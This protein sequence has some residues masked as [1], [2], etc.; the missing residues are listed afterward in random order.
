M[1]SEDADRLRFA[2]EA[3]DALARVE[4]RLQLHLSLLF[5][6]QAFL[7][8][9]ERD[10]S[11]V[12]FADF[13]DHL[14][15]AGRYDGI[16]GVGFAMTVPADAEGPA[17]DAIARNYGQGFPIRP[18][19]TDQAIRT[20]IV[21]IEPQD[22]RNRAAVG[23]DMFSAETRRTAMIAAART[24]G[25]QAT[26]P[27]RLVQEIDENRQQGFLIYLP[28]FANPL[29]TV[30]EAAATRGF[31]YAPFR[32]GDLFQAAFGHK[33]HLPVHVEV[34]DGAV[35]TPEARIYASPEAA[36]PQWGE[37]LGATRELTVAGRKWLLRMHPTPEF[38][39]IGSGYPAALLAAAVVMLALVLALLTLVQS[40]R[41]EAVAAL[42]AEGVR[43]LAQKDLMLGEMNHRIKNSIAR[44]IAIARQTARGASGLDDFMERYASRLNAMAA[45]QEVLTRSR[46]GRA[47]M[48]ELLTRELSQVLGEGLENCNIAGPE[49]ELGEAATQALGLTFHE[50]AT[51]ALKYGAL[52]SQNGSLSVTWR[53]VGET[54]AIDWTETGGAAPV[55]EPQRRGFGT[56]LINMSIGSELGGTIERHFA[57]SG[58][59][60]AIRFPAEAAGAAPA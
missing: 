15:L 49:V 3:D 32:V 45:A 48:D 24:G 56:R 12:Q 34:F 11:R 40:R 20:P 54:V 35:A 17:V 26:G 7:A 2:Q 4:A 59:R 28:L 47:K 31:V 23:F 27:V 53:L 39:R 58:L 57:E 50:L 51:N 42:N 9:E 6:T 55:A 44:V 33:A 38:R 13:V 30:G 18:Q 14:D 21:L 10:V 22:A 5:A 36:D 16:Q 41:A 43:N 52:A 19:A 25:A 29:Q 8:V 37:R 60:I 1:S 46:W